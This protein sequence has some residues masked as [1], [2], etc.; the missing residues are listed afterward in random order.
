MKL[1]VAIVD[2][3]PTFRSSIAHAVLS[4]SDMLL[5]GV[6]D[7]L[8]SGRTLVDLR[9]PEVLLV[10]LGL[11]GGSGIDLIRYAAERS[12]GCDVMVVTVFGD[13][14]HVMASIEAG[15]TGYLLKDRS[16]FDLAE[17]IRAL[18]AGGSPI[19]PI[20][21]RQLLKRLPATSPLGAPP[22][23]PHDVPA[24]GALSARE[25]EVLG[26]SA[27]GHTAQEI[28]AMLGVSRE[29]VLTYVKRTYR[30]L[31]VHS[32]IAAIRE[33]RRVGWLPGEPR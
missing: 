24:D 27:R 9:Q 17:Q 1:T 14:R 18:R 21:A 29:S 3:D 33:A 19:S 13:E 16:D 6:A 22:K 26:L 32:K 25:R 23:G 4:A 31:Q 15:A 11:P 5:L 10:D 12:P 28:A 2:D 7:D 8:E 30:K 20:I